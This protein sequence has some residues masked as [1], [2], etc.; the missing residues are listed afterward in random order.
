MCEN[1]QILEAKG[2]ILQT[3]AYTV[4]EPPYL[5]HFLYGFHFKT[6]LFYHQIYKF[7]VFTQSGSEQDIKIYNYHRNCSLRLKTVPPCT[8]LN[9]PVT[10]AKSVAS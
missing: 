6:A 9:T 3:G 8:I 10:N 7:R 4:T 5:L 1:S 2:I